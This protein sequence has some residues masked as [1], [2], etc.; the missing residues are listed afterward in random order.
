[1]LSAN[2][3]Q[4]VLAFL[5]EAER[6]KSVIRSGYTSTGRPESTAEHTWRLS[7]M[8]ML[9]ADGLGDIDVTRLLKICIVHDLGEALHG[10]VPAVAQVEGDDRA[11][12]ERADIETLTLSLD[13]KRRAEIM[14]LWHEYETGASP[15]GRLAKGLDKLETIL[16]HT[17]GLNPVD[18]DYA[19]NIDYGTKFTAVHPLVSAIRAELDNETKARMA[20]QQASGASH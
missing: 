8:A 3:I 5:R 6:L 15:E 20:V 14:A 9:L 10:D 1:M 16:Q 19:F 12:R 11:A 4:G 13:D 18:F 7:L 17:Q 2:E